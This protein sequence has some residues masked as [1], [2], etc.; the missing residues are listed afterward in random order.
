MNYD[1]TDEEL[2][3]LHAHL[4]KITGEVIRVCEHLGIGYFIIGGS[5]IG[6]YYWDGIIPW[7]DDIDI[8]MLRSD[9]ERFLKEAPA[10]LGDDYFLQWVG[11]DVHTPAWFAKVREHHTVF[12][13]TMAKNV[14][15]H[16]GIYVDIFPFDKIPRSRCLERLQWH[17]VNFLNGCFIGKEIWQLKYFGRCDMPEPRKR[18]WLPC[19]VTRVVNTLLTKKQLYQLMKA[20]QTMFNRSR[21]KY[22]KNIVTTN[23]T[24]RIEHVL[25]PQTV[26]FGSL[27]VYAPADLE[28]YLHTHYPVLKKHL[29][30]EEQINHRPSELVFDT[31][32]KPSAN[33]S[34]RP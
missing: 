3:Q 7:D 32:K 12:A 13:E 20:A 27:Q 14:K 31:R 2:K 24:V 28:A 17:L 11:S 16:H 19:L 5:A 26:A 10:V 8:G 6:A 23:D 15:M 34:F 33:Q 30:K 9:Y 25:H 18:G 22:C 1:Y 21:G 4:Y 29:P